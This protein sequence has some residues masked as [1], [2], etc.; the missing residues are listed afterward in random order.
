M[1]GKKGIFLGG[2]RVDRTRTLSTCERR[3]GAVRKP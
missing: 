3:E 2:G 1:E